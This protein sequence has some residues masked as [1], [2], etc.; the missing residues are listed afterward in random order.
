MP[1]NSS[2]KAGGII[3]SALQDTGPF[4]AFAS[5]PLCYVDVGAAGGMPAEITAA[6][7][8]IQAV[9]FEPDK[10]EYARV[11]DAV[12]K[13]GFAAV[14]GVSSA[15]AG[16]TETRT[17]HLTRSR[18]NSSLLLP[19]AAYWTRYRNPGAEIELTCEMPCTTM[20]AALADLRTPPD[21]IKTDCQGLD[22]DILAAA[23]RCLDN[24]VCVIPEIIIADAYVGQKG[25]AEI[26]SLLQAHGFTMY[27]L[28]PHYVS[29]RH[30]DRHRNETNERLMHID[31]IFFKD[32]FCRA[33]DAKPLTQRQWQ[34]LFAAA[35]IYGYYDFAIELSQHMEDNG[36]LA[37]GARALALAAG[38]KIAALFQQATGAASPAEEE[39]YLRAKLFCSEVQANN[40]VAHLKRPV[41]VS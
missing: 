18:V 23:P 32:P 26:H 5:T 37:E 14:H 40:D 19:K 29:C 41:M 2:G 17:L 15:L 33:K 39:P 22:H 8:F 38:Q 24:A 6:A 7:P 36:G 28:T 35:C 31:G 4:R 3:G 13:Q 21:I 11:L 9:F 27:G 16:K 25:L 10:D 34:A 12:Q 30:L 20:D 1:T